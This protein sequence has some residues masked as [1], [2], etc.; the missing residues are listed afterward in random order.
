MERLE[1]VVR[2]KTADG[3]MQMWA[4][5]LAPVVICGAIHKLD[6]TYFAPLTSTT[7]GYVALTIAIILYVAGLFI[8]RKVLAVDI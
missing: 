6:P 8:A 7:I 2:Q 3:R 4:L 5:S 1:G